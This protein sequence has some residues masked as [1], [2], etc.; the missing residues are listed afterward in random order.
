MTDD[1]TLYGQRYYGPSVV[2]VDALTFSAAEMFAAGFLDNRIGSIIGAGDHRTG[3]AGANV[4]SLHSLDDVLGARPRLRSNFFKGADLRFSARQCVRI[5]PRGRGFSKS[6]EG[7]GITR[8]ISHRLTS[9]DALNQGEDI[10]LAAA[11]H[12]APAA[13]RA[14]PALE[15]KKRIVGRRR[16][17]I[18]V[19]VIGTNI[20][21]LR[22][23]ITEF[24]GSGEPRF[25]RSNTGTLNFRVDRTDTSIIEVTGFAQNGE[26][27]HY[28]EE[29]V[30]PQALTDELER[31]RARARRSRRRGRRRR[32]R[33]ARRA[34]RGR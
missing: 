16:R 25:K 28:K 11:R 33:R 8:T 2:L 21:K 14:R 24:A 19:T 4:W 3:G 34:R 26:R 6:F 10:L 18:D 9:K 32:R 13:K 22:A 23:A 7:V 27:A 12:L 31:E 20:T 1:T 17:E 30:P 15:V 5:S 29:F